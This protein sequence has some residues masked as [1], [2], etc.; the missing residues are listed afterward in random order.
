MPPWLTRMTFTIVAFQQT[1][2]ILIESRDVR[3]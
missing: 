2:K 3:G 1:W